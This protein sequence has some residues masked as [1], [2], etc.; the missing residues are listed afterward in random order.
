[1]DVVGLDRVV[2]QSEP[3]SL[4]GDAET[5]LHLAHETPDPERRHVAPNA[6][7]HVTR[8]PS[9]ERRPASV[10]VAPDRPRLASRP[11]AASAPARR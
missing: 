1:V 6:K 2:D 7:R 3:P 4:A 9:R 8:M 10:G 5:P 11:G